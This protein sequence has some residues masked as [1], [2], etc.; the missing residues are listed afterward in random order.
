[1]AT[2]NRVRSSKS[3]TVGEGE[4]STAVPLRVHS[5]EL[6]AR[7]LKVRELEDDNARLRRLWEEVNDSWAA[8]RAERDSA[9]AALEVA[10][11]RLSAMNEALTATFDGVTLRERTPSFRGQRFPNQLEDDEDDE[12]GDPDQPIPYSPTDPVPRQKPA[13]A[14][15][16]GCAAKGS[17]AVRLDS[18]RGHD[19]HGT[20]APVQGMLRGS[21]IPGRRKAR[22]HVRR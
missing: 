16:S 1:M 19:V 9:T 12:D 21:G 8:C 6:A 10:E 18:T 7:D 5:A 4:A 11:S 3:Q 17:E 13:H 2:T 20:A 22:L 15:C 14:G